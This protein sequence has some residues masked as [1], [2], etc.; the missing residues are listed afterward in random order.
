[1]SLQLRKQQQVYVEADAEDEQQQIQSTL[2]EDVDLQQHLT[3]DMFSKAQDIIID[4][5][6]VAS[7]AELSASLA[8]NKWQLAAYLTSRFKQNLATSN[9]HLADAAQLA[10]N[11][12]RCVPLHLEILQHQN[13]FPFAMGLNI[14]GMMPT[15][16]HKHGECLWRV[17]AGTAT[18]K[19]NEAAFSPQNLINQYMYANYRMC[20]VEDLS[21]DLVHV[22]GNQ[23]QGTE[24]HYSVAVGSFAYSELIRGLDAGHWQDQ[25]DEV[26]IEHIDNPGRS[27]TVTI[28]KKMGD[29]LHASI[30][31]PVEEVANSFINLENLVAEFVRADGINEF[32]SPKNIA[33]EIVGS[34]KVSGTKLNTDMLQTRCTFHVRGKLTYLLF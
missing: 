29:D 14:A 24:D 12:N 27:P 32:N 7:P 16:L 10:G 31:G 22:K 19:V 17:P 33:G 30:R 8:A 11:L 3:K 34:D 5:D 23:K 21:S 20:T 15:T 6:L 2:A 25:M 28:T 4:F 1:M 26:N 13:T 9:R 18:M